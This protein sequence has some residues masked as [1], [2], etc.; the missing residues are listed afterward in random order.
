MEFLR[1]EILARKQQREAKNPEIE[2]KSD[3]LDIKVSS[4]SVAL[5]VSALS[6]PLP[7]SEFEIIF[8]LRKLKQPAKLFGETIKDQYNRLKAS[9]KKVIEEGGLFNKSAINLDKL[10][11]ELEG[12]PNLYHV[13]EYLDQGKECQFY[14]D[15]GL[16]WKK[17]K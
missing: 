9:E 6:N 15:N 8:R 1:K 2:K 14:E 4:E 11:E 10:E 12:D 16:V 7:L 13:S 5:G 17:E 3:A